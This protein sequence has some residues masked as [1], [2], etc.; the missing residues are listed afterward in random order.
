MERISDR[1]SWSYTPARW[2]LWVIFCILT[3]Y[4][5]GWWYLSTTLRCMMW[6]LCIT[7]LD[8][9]CAAFWAL[10]S[11]GAIV[12]YLMIDKEWLANAW[13]V[14]LYYFLCMTVIVGLYQG[15]TIENHIWY[16]IDQK[17]DP[18]LYNRNRM[19]KKILW[20]W[21]SDGTI[22]SK[23]ASYSP[24]LSRRYQQHGGWY[25][26]YIKSILSTVISI[27]YRYYYV[28]LA[29]YGPWLVQSG[30]LIS[31]DRL[32]LIVRSWGEIQIPW[33]LFPSISLLRS[34]LGLPTWIINNVF[35]ILPFP[36]LGYYAYR[37]LK[38]HSWYVQWFGVLFAMFNPF[39]YARMADWQLNVVWMYVGLFMLFVY[40]HR[41]DTQIRIQSRTSRTQR[42][43]PIIVLGMAIPMFSIHGMFPLLLVVIMHIICMTWSL[44]N[45]FIF[46][47]STLSAIVITNLY[48]IVPT[49][50]WSNDA[51]ATI[52]QMWDTH[53]QAFAT[54]AGT[55]N[56]YRNTL[57]LRW[58]R[59]ESQ[60]R[61][62]PHYLF[63]SNYHMIMLCILILVIIGIYTYRT[64][65]SKTIVIYTSIGVIAWILSHGNEGIFGPLSR[66]LYE[67]VPGYVG[68]R[69]PHKWISVLV[70]VYSYLG[71]IG[72]GYSIDFFKDHH[73]KKWVLYTILAIC[74]ALPILYTPAMLFGLW[75][76][77]KP[78]HY[79]SDRQE[80]KQYMDL[81]PSVSQCQYQNH[82]R[83]VPCYRALVLPRHGYMTI[84]RVDK[85]VGTSISNYF[86]SGLLIGDPVEFGGIYSQTNRP[87]SILIQSFVSN[88]SGLIIDKN[89][90]AQSF[91]KMLKSMGI[92]ELIILKEAD[93]NLYDSGL[94]LIKPFMQTKIDN[95]SVRLYHIR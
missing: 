12:V 13:A 92:S 81:V 24:S 26:S 82:Y 61:F 21:F 43:V 66:V 67:M 46:L 11:L 90:S 87:A 19:I 16:Y 63:N 30:Y 18:L 83:N 49:L 28:G 76:Q 89:R 59:W 35:W 5:V 93:R 95:T 69:E 85:R 4:L 44:K 75:G 9:R 7:G 8:H 14:L 91:V 88:Q 37:L 64:Q 52:I 29:I 60:Q 56:L 47:I 23:I 15:S 71:A 2:L 34:T 1:S 72:L 20:T 6:F 80:V 33:F 48:R 25:I 22:Q 10:G 36:L 17:L 84:S 55:T 39:V 45:K 70:I 58:Y 54:Q 94:Q 40:L 41:H 42:I 32:P 57:S 50:S 3:R 86:W 31:L 51:G 53:R 74:L 62:L 68:L 38:N 78:M 79:P 27:K 73:I 77:I 65:K